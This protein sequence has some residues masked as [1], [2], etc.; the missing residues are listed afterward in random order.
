[1]ATLPPSKRILLVE[2]SF[3]TRELLSTILGCHGYMVATAANGA[4]ALEKLRSQPAPDVILLDVVMPVMDGWT[5]AEMI[6]RDERLAGIPV[7]VI[8]GAVDAECVA[9]KLEDARFL[10]K[11]VDTADLLQA[12]KGCSCGEKEQKKQQ[13][14][15]AAGEAAEG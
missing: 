7:V 12:V 6:G 3:S 10:Q 8:S 2:D 1:M 13:P 11:P 9:K 15:A 4:E 14:A 5:L